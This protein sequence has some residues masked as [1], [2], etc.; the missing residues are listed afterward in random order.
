MGRNIGTLDQI[1]RQA[2]GTALVV[3]WI[4]GPLGWWAILGFYPLVTGITGV[5][6]IYPLLGVS[7][8]KP[9]AAPPGGPMT[10]GPAG[11]PA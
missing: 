5:C 6:P 2:I 8:R 4:F 11:P 7:T 10:E 9:A 3:M 1:L